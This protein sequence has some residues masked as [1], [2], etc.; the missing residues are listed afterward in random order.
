MNEAL[1]GIPDSLSGY[2]DRQNMTRQLS[3]FKKVRAYLCDYGH[4]SRWEHWHWF[5]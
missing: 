3:R 1:E 2:I 5:V 4:I